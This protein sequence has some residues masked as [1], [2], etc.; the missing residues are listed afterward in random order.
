MNIDGYECFLCDDGTLDTVISIDGEEIR[1]SQ[2]YAANFRDSDGVMTDEGF[3][4]LCREEIE[5][6]ET[7]TDGRENIFEV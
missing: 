7:Y 6:M 1:F 4:E 2:D 3:K 5:Q